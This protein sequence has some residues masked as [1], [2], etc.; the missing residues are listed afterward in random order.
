M[1]EPFSFLRTKAANF[2][3]QKNNDSDWIAIKKK[4]KVLWKILLS[5]GLG[6]F[7]ALSF[8]IIGY[9]NIDKP[10]IASIIGQTSVIFITILSWL[11]LKEKISTLRIISMLVAISGVILITIK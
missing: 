4:S 5:S 11:I 7:I 9:A 8:W 2:F 10:P 6:T 3:L 1:I